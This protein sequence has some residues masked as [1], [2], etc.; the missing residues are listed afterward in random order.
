MLLCVLTTLIGLASLRYLLPHIPFAIHNANLTSRRPWLVTHATSASIALLVGPWQFVKSLRTSRKQWHRRIGWVYLIAVLIGW[1]SSIPVSIHA[2]AG[3]VSQ[4]GFLALGA[5]WITTTSLGLLTAV[6]GQ[7]EKHRRWM[8]RSY[9][10]TAA[11]ITLRIMLPISLLCGVPF[12]YAY[13]VIAW[14]CWIA[15]LCCAEYFLK[16][17]SNPTRHPEL[18]SPALHTYA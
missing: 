4:A 6:K 1:I 11:A 18:I 14:A 16:A 13:P 15:N 9:A 3:P 17:P 8:T 10:V 5:A 7:F 12:K 2:A